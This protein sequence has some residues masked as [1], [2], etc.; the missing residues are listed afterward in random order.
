MENLDQP[1]IG[2]GLTGKNL[3]PQCNERP[4]YLCGLALGGGR[5]N[6]HK[7]YL[8]CWGCNMVR[9]VDMARRVMKPWVQ[10]KLPKK[11]RIRDAG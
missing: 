5:W 10:E 1:P 4:D 8:V 6:V 7:T 11:V 9:M 2:L 3:C